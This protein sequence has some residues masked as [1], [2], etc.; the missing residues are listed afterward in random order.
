MSKVD[1]QEFESPPK[2]TEACAGEKVPENNSGFENVASWI[3]RESGQATD[4]TDTR[5]RKMTDKGREYQ[6]DLKMGF[7]KSA[8]Q[9]LTRKMDSAKSSVRQLSRI[10][11]EQLRDNLDELKDEFNEAHRA[12]EALLETEAEKL[13]SYQWFDQ[14]DREFM[15]CRIRVCQQIRTCEES[16]RRSVVSHRSNRSSRSGYSRQSRGSHVSSNYSALKIEI[17][18][19]A[20]RLK[21]EK[22]FFE[23]E[24]EYKRLLL[25]REVAISKAE[26]EALQQLE[27]DEQNA[28]IKP[29]QPKIPDQEIA[30]QSTQN[31]P[32]LAVKSESKHDEKTGPSSSASKQPL[33]SQPTPKESEVEVITKLIGLQEKQTELTALIADQQRINSLPVQEPP[34]FSGDSFDFPAFITAFDAIILTKVTSEK[35]KL[36]FLNKYTTGKANEIVKGF[37]SLNSKNGYEEARKLLEQRFGN[38]VKV[39][40]AFK[41]RLRNWPAIADGNSVALQDLADFLVRCDEAMKVSNSMNELN[42][43]EVLKEISAK[44]PSYSGVKWCRQAHEAQKKS[45]DKCVNFHDFVKFV[46]DESEL[47]NDPIFS[48][49]AM[50]DLRLKKK[51]DRGDKVTPKHAPK[52]GRAT[53][54]V[55]GS[56][57]VPASKP[58]YRKPAEKSASFLC[59][60]CKSNSHSLENC[61]KFMEKPME[62]RK[63]FIQ[64]NRMCFGCLGNDGHFSKQCKNRLTCKECGR[65]HPTPLHYASPSK[66]STPAQGTASA[67]PS[68]EA[69]ANAAI[70]NSNSAPASSVVT[71]CLIVPVLLSHKDRPETEV[72]VYA[73]L[74]D[75]S[76]TTFIKESVRE[77]LGIEGLETTLQLSTMLG[78]EKIAVRKV[79]GLVAKRL[80]KQVE[81]QLP[82]TYTS[83]S[84]PSRRD[85]IPTPEIADTWAH[86]KKIKEKIPPIQEDAEVGL[87]IGCNCP[88][89]LKPKEV[90]LGS[91]EDPYAIRTLLGWGI[92]G[93]VLGKDGDEDVVTCNRIVARELVPESRNTLSFVLQGNAKEV[94]DPGAVK[95]F[96]EQ[97]FSER[98]DSANLG[99]SKEDRRFLDIAEDGV[100]QHEDG[101]YELPLPF[102]KPDVNLPDN[103][104]VVKR[105]LMRLKFKFAADPQYKEEYTAFME[106]MINKGYAEKVTDAPGEQRGEEG[107]VKVWRI[108][109]HGVRHPKKGTIRCVFNCA[110]EY[111]GESLNKH[112]LQG[113]DL[114]NNLVGVLSRFRKEPVAFT[115]DIESMFYQ[116]KVAEEH[117]DYLR[118]LWWEGGDTSKDPVEYRMTVHL[119]GATSSPGCANFALKKAA[120]DS[121]SELGSAAAQFIS[122][123]FY[124]DDGLKSCATVSEAKDLITSV[125]QICK[126]GGF[127]LHKFV[128][129]DKE[130]IK[131]IPESDRAEGLKELNLD[132]DSLPLERA[133]GVEWC[134]ESDCFQFRIHLQDKPCTRRGI[135]STVSSIF[136]PL[137]LVAPLLLEGKNIL[138]V[139]CRGKVDWDDP[140]PEETKARWE[141]WRLD[142]QQLRSVTIPRCYKPA[143]F[144]EVITTELH[145]FSDASTKGYGQCSYVR[146]VNK[147]GEI[148]CSLV[149]G[150]SRVTPLKPVT[151]PRLELTAA[152]TSVKVSQ[153]S[154]VE[155]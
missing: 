116:V 153:Q 26:E 74:D 133:L 53:S 126:R 95:N 101:H 115:C 98:K 25:D 51:S 40:E 8:Y 64:A 77:Q 145:H 112:L 105:H 36:F 150:K 124:V 117:R 61:T 37:L 123:D 78:R 14:R 130:V 16:D 13:L 149:L 96:F 38:K 66:T 9:R 62:K 143:D 108:P 65:H 2:E 41:S 19:R 29:L 68:D 32:K 60:L 54:L 113:P 30:K 125:K 109:H 18:T 104:D 45:E 56:K 50:K 91:G 63:E 132:L 43:T 70:T 103:Y 44:L 140:I 75:A 33:Q 21:V 82:K 3:P 58:V 79:E 154:R 24:V 97:D 151:I 86:L 12:Y 69:S 121:E 23:K 17:K 52:S 28:E 152:T 89:A 76:D 122:R 31:V 134:V 110:F 48:P 129:N 107:S 142:L 72:K 46:R 144:G 47:A 1:A 100:L 148:H 67:K 7:R 136:D 22:D 139:L 5:E 81:I 27:K 11:L 138:Q 141:K 35:D 102:K 80:D 99:L 87:L 114:T 131:D 127:N 155:N 49:D 93:P 119:F 85:Q 94:I 90:I 137:G 39:A 88:K 71:N 20:A 135:L 84:I 73:L 55:T 106:K 128:S 42:S 59:Q 6:L 146:Y 57:T 118:F 83:D 120:E 15:E 147:R 4:I 92:V 111:K 10:E 34:T